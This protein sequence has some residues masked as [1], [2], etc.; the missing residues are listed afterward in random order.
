M[1]I[2]SSAEFKGQNDPA[3]FDTRL[4]IERIF[5]GGD[6][7]GKTSA[8][9]FTPCTQFFPICSQACLILKALSTSDFNGLS[10]SCIR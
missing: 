7:S 5:R 10:K 8:E 2:F 4:V 6:V 3:T 9:R 1:G